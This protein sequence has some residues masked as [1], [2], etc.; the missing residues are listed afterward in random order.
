MEFLP[1]KLTA[2]EQQEHADYAEMIRLFGVKRRPQDVPL[3]RKCYMINLNR[4][5]GDLEQRAHPL[6]TLP[7]YKEQIEADQQRDLRVR[8]AI[9]GNDTVLYFAGGKFCD[10]IEATDSPDVTDISVLR[11]IGNHTAM[12]LYERNIYTGYEGDALVAVTVTLLE[13]QLDGVPRLMGSVIH[14]DNSISTFMYR[15][16]ELDDGLATVAWGSGVQER[17]ES[18]ITNEERLISNTLG[19]LAQQSVFTVTEWKHYPRAVVS[20]AARE[21]RKLPSINVLGLA[22]HVQKD[23]DDHHE[24]I[25][26][27]RDFCWPVRGHFRKQAY[28]PDRSM[29]KLKYIRPHVKGNLEGPL[30]ARPQ[31]HAAK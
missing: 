9:K 2:A 18:D 29:R 15:F 21:R 24:A 27:E 22:R 4:R 26:I 13:T 8:A 3:F 16:E 28:G 17:I 25:R 31:V 10:L 30:I 19:L 5:E 7:Q 1:V 12:V 6:A 20:A 11:R 23:L 14:E